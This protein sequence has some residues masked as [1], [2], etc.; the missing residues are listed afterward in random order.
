LPQYGRFSRLR[1]PVAVVRLGVLGFIF[2]FI[3]FIS[4]TSRFLLFLSLSLARY[5]LLGK[6]LL[7]IAS[8]HSASAKAAKVRQASSRHRS[9][10]LIISFDATK[11]GESH[12]ILRHKRAGSAKQL[13]CQHHRSIHN[14]LSNNDGAQHPFNLPG[15]VDGQQR[16]FSRF[17]DGDSDDEHDSYV[18]RRRQRRKR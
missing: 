12:L 4:V 17:V 16:L 15:S 7:I 14:P 5:V 1:L 6:A 2:Y 11:R 18:E 13:S 10:D 9:L 3:S 8:F